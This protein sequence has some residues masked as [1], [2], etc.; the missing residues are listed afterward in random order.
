MPRCKK[1]GSPIVWNHDH[2]EETGKWVPFDE[3]TD[4]PHN[5]P[6]FDWKSGSGGN[7]GGIDGVDA[8]AMSNAISNLENKMD[9]VNKNMMKLILAIQIVQSRIEGQMPLFPPTHDITAKPITE[10]IRDPADLTEDG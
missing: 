1:C 8:M 4:E 2:Y 5:C 3:D 10:P 9:E 7:W 6:E